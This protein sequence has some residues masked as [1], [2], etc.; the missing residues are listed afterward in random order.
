MVNNQ[1]LMVI[2]YW[3]SVKL[4]FENSKSLRNKLTKNQEPKTKN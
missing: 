1:W 2:G 4:K 3:L